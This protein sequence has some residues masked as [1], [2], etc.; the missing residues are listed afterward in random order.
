MRPKI[1]LYTKLH[2]QIATYWTERRNAKPGHTK[3]HFSETPQ[4]RYNI[5]RVILIGPTSIMLIMNTKQNNY[6]T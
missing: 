1:S 2:T 6:A 3:D 4:F 5:R